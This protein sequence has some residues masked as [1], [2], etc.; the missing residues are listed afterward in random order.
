MSPSPHAHRIATLG[1]SAEAIRRHYDIEKILAARLRGGSREERLSLYRTV[2]DDLFR[3]LPDHPQLVRKQSP[4]QTRHKISAQLG[5]LGPYLRRDAVFLE[6]GAGDCALSLEIA[7][8][9]KQVFAVDVSEQITAGVQ[10]PDNLTVV[11]CDG[12]TIPLPLNTVDMV[13]SNQLIEH[14]HPDDLVQQLGSVRSVLRPNGTYLCVT[15]NRLNGPHDISKY[16]DDEA[17][18]LHI[19]EYTN[20]EVQAL[21]LAEGFSDCCAYAGAEGRYLR[22]PVSLPVTIETI[23]QRFPI[24]IRRSIARRP[25]F[26]ALLGVRMAARA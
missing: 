19:K 13:Y 9:V 1:R 23:L 25:P 18:G 4:E 17:T 26:T 6:L 12:C 14:V 15:P 11:I 7:K 10:R 5:L 24:S 21:F 2:Y 20:A 8:R 16:F 3:L 22:L